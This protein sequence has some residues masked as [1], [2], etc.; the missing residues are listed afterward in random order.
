[1]QPHSAHLALLGKS[2]TRQ[3]SEDG[4]CIHGADYSCL[5]SWIQ[6]LLKSRCSR[7][8]ALY[9]KTCKLFFWQISGLLRKRTSPLCKGVFPFFWELNRPI[10][11]FATK[12][13]QCCPCPRFV[14]ESRLIE[15]QYVLRRNIF[16]C[17]LQFMDVIHDDLELSAAGLGLILGEKIASCK[18]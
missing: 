18:S 11:I 2:C 1:M 4:T 6:I 9:W 10:G 12:P 5:E 17:F 13:E 3:F 15:V 14:G 8:Q 7:V 16:Q